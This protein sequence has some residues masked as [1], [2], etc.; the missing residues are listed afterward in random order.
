MINISL[1]KLF[2][3]NGILLWSR[4]NWYARFQKLH[5]HIQMNVYDAAFELYN[6]ALGIYLDKYNDFSDARRSKIDTKYY[7]INLTLNACDYVLYHH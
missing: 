7:H 1:I 3:F 6:E 5:T 4:K 2:I